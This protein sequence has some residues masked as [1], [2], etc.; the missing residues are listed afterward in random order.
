VPLLLLPAARLTLL[1]R[2]LLC[3]PSP[4]LAAELWCLLL[5]FGALLLVPGTPPGPA[6]ADDADVLLLLPLPVWRRPVA[7]DC[8]PGAVSAGSKGPSSH[9]P[10]LWLHDSQD[11]HMGSRL[12]VVVPHKQAHYMRSYMLLAHMRC[13]PHTHGHTLRAYRQASMHACVHVHMHTSTCTHPSSSYAGKHM[14]NSA[15]DCAG[16]QS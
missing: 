4:P 9:R 3:T 10:R 12:L 2:L 1:P 8:A 7:R 5:L 14:E 11:L 16:M 15:P 6:A 13:W